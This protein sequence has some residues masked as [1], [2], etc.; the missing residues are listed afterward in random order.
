[1]AKKKISVLGASGY[2]GGE[3]LR[4]LVCHPEVEV[5]HLT[6]D[7]YAGKRVWEIIPNL[8]GFL[9]L[10]LE[11]LVPNSLPD[12]VDIFLAALPHHASAEIVKVILDIGKKVIDLSADFRLS[13]GTY[14]DWYGN[15]PFPELIGEAVYGLTELFREEIARSRLVANPGCY[16]TASILGLA[17]L[18]KKH[19]IELESIII[20]AK[21]GVS[22]AGRSPEL[23]YSFSEVNEGVK[24]YKVGEHRHAPE[25]EEVLSKIS[26]KPVSISFTPHLIPM[27]RG[28][29]ATIYVKLLYDMSTD[30]I[31]GVYR[32][33]Y[34]KDRFIRVL[35][36]GV[37][38]STS[39]VRGSNFCDI[40][41]KVVDSKRKSTIVVSAIDNLVKGASGQAIQN[42]NVMTEFEESLG[43][44]VPPVFP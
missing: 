6:A 8:R 26:E 25:I 24:A 37:F 17:P 16:P 18:V 31:L 13:Y 32:E 42:M 27:D 39:N 5:V 7:K 10:T 1:M 28:I 2:T 14:L 12:E 19:L 4:F 44:D 3:L 15:H 23:A 35:P 30:E 40:G 9:D 33:F 20:D 43:I 41:I 22:G 34:H 29:L 21:S 36:K 38:P 11:P